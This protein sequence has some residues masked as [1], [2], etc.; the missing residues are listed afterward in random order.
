M[1][2]EVP[3]HRAAPSVALHLGRRLTFS[4]RLMPVP[5]LALSGPSFLHR[6]PIW[7]FL[8][9]GRSFSPCLQSHLL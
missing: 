6:R 1:A 5:S 8:T 9:S 2:E 3:T 4:L 7:S